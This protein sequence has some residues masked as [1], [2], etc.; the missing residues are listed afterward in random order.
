MP[1]QPHSTACRTRS[2][3]KSRTDS[4]YPICRSA[5]SSRLVSAL[6]A[7]TFVCVE[8]ALPATAAR[9]ISGSPC[10]VTNDMPRSTARA[11]PCRTVSPMSY[12][13]ASRNTRLPC[14]DQPVDEPLCPRARTA[15]KAR[16]CRTTRCPPVA[17]R[18]PPPPRCS[19]RPAPRS[20]V[21]TSPPACRALLRGCSVRHEHILLHDVL[22]GGTPTRRMPDEKR[23]SGKA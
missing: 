5:A 20:G 16:S 12:I 22:T 15:A 14:A 9:M 7:K 1:S 11:T 18:A 23:G 4:A 8:P 3:I 21:R 17:E 2:L 10:T 19:A 6:I 13:F